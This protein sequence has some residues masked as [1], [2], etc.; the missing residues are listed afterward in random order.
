MP[1]AARRSGSAGDGRR[2]RAQQVGVGPTGQA[3]ERRAGEELEAD[4]RRHRVAGQPEHGRARSPDG[5]KANGLAGRMAICIQR[6]SPIAVE[7]HLHEV[8]VAHR[9]AAAR[10]DGV[11]G[12]RRRRGWRPR[13]ASSSSAHEAE[14]DRRRRRP[15][16]PA[17]AAWAGWSRGSGPGPSGAPGGTSSSPVDST[18]TRGRGW[19]STSVAPM[20]AS[21]PRWPGVSTLAGGEHRVAGVQVVARGPH[22]QARRHLRLDRHDGAVGAALGALDHHD[23]VGAV[24]HRRAGHD[25]HRLARRRARGRRGGRPPPRPRPA[26]RPA[27]LGGAGGVGRPHGVAVHRRVGE[28][29]HVRRRRDGLGEHEPGR[30]GPGHRQRARR[31]RRRPARG[32]G[33]GPRRAGSRPAARSADA[34]L[35]HVRRRARRGT[36]GRGPRGPAPARRW[37]GGSRACCRCRSGRRR[38]CSRA[39]PRWR[40]ACRWRR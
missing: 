28:R 27:R 30:V 40:G 17:R 21:T 33:P 32:R 37:P 24:G 26:A 22:V 14:V 34:L 5:P 12:R 16:R 3:P 29:R 36:R 9:H 11:A 19:A 4:H 31:Q 13:M 6:M 7:H 10:E 18:P 38:T 23:R 1:S 25:P 20:P 8:D 2:R 15:P 35:A 39:P